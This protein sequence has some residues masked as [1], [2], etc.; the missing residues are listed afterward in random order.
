MESGTRQ[1]LSIRHWNQAHPAARDTPQDIAMSAALTRSSGMPARLRVTTPK[2]NPH[3]SQVGPRTLPTGLVYFLTGSTIS[4]L[5]GCHDRFRAGMSS[6]PHKDT[7]ARRPSL[8][9]RG[10]LHEVFNQSDDSPRTRRRKPAPSYRRTARPAISSRP[11]R[12][13]PPLPST[14]TASQRRKRSA[15]RRRLRA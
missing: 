1:H 12:A 7:P 2:P 5:S 10:Q 4:G 14:C 13:A 15:A 3:L 6:C 11:F 9:A 8:Q